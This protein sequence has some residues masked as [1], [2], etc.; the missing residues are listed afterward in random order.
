MPEVVA[1]ASA[2]E[3]PGFGRRLLRCRFRGD[4]G[5]GRGVLK[6]MAA[7]GLFADRR[8]RAGGRTADRLLVWH[9]PVAAESRSYRSAVQG[10]H[11]KRVRNAT[12]MLIRAC[13]CCRRQHG[14]LAIL[15][16]YVAVTLSRARRTIFPRSLLP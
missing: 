2:D 10:R 7:S 16:L 6:S 4:T 11:C 15:T 12:Q 8:S 14:S 3:N 5:E 1:A 9:E 13:C